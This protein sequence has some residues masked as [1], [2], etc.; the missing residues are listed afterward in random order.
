MS[1]RTTNGSAAGSSLINR[2]GWFVATMILQ[3]SDPSSRRLVL[4]LEGMEIIVDVE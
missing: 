2:L 1:L 4:D 3:R